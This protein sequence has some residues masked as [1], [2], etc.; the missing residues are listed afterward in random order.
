VAFNLGFN[1]N[2]TDIDRIAPNPPALEDL[3]PGFVLFDR[4]RQGNLTYGFPDYKG[5]VGVNWQWRKLN[6]NIRLVRFGGYRTTNNNPASEMDVEA[7][8]IV[9]LDFTFQI[10]EHASATV[11]AS[12]VFNTYPTQILP[13]DPIRGSGQ[14]STRGGFGFTGGAYYARFNLTY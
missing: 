14:Y 6:T 7:E 12:N 8:N 5:V 3:G 1:S 9:D 13:P 2:N 11:G 10:G 4:T